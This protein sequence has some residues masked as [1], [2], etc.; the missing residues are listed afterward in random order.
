[1]SL[2]SSRLE[3][4]LTTTFICSERL[5][6]HLLFILVFTFAHPLSLFRCTIH[7]NDDLSL[8]PS[9]D[10]GGMSHLFPLLYVR[11]MK[12]FPL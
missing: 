8:S 6:L 10:V 12:K 4:S 7:V 3:K 1:M 11:S 2:S 9:L 5:C